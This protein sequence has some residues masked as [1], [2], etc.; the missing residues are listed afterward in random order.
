MNLIKNAGSMKKNIIF[1]AMFAIVGMAVSCVNDDMS[2][3]PAGEI[4]LKAQ[5]PEISVQ[6]RTY[7][8]E[9]RNPMW[10]AGDRLMVYNIGTQ[11]E[12]INAE[13]TATANFKATISNVDAQAEN[14]ALFPYA[15]VA[16]ND[17]IQ[18]TIPQIQHPAVGTFDGDADVLIS[19]M[20]KM[21]GSNLEV[22]FKRM[23]AVVKV[24]L[25]D[26]DNLL[27]GDAVTELNLSVTSTDA[28]KSY[29]L[30][31]CRM[32]NLE[33]ASFGDWASASTSVKAEVAEGI[34]F[35][36]GQAD[37]YLVVAPQ[38]V[39]SDAVIVVSAKTANGKSL[40]FRI[41]LATSGIEEM[42]LGAGKV[43]TIGLKV[44]S[45][46]SSVK[47]NS[48]GTV[49]LRVDGEKL[50]GGYDRPYV[51]DATARKLGRCAWK[52]SNVNLSDGTSIHLRAMPKTCKWDGNDV[53]IQIYIK[54]GEVKVSLTGKLSTWDGKYF[55]NWASGGKS[56]TVTTGVPTDMS[57]VETVYFMLSNTGTNK[58]FFK[59][60]IN[61]TETAI[62]DIWDGSVLN[63][64]ATANN[65]S[66]AAHESG[67]YW[68]TAIHGGTGSITLDAFK[69][70]Q[71]AW[72]T[73]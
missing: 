9:E 24:S 60:Y 70:D 29:P 59:L 51:K 73:F 55:A 63:P 13:N 22:N 19:E 37:V 66:G 2:V 49:T 36:G 21:S 40:S 69:F 6:S 23:T 67:L 34:P 44:T 15:N 4:T 27:T 28:S 48:D 62:F 64:W 41:A 12:F 53:A 16:L 32:V 65:I 47:T 26:P 43:S 54:S 68:E 52:F 18:M 10:S 38:T 61:G 3:Q 45:T 35:V 58:A 30:T 50:A 20:F 1:S 25:K 71:W 8:D 33:N 14:Y 57:T 17:G 56:W 11:Y 5:N 7:I 31:G 42:V 46:N 72:P 39:A